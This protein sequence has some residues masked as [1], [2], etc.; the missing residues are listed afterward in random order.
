[1]GF[2]REPPS[3]Q[4]C[5]WEER[6]GAPSPRPG[7]SGGRPLLQ[8]ALWVPPP[9]SALHLLLL[10]PTA[11][12]RKRRVSRPAR[13]LADL[14]ELPSGARGVLPICQ[15]S[16]QVTLAP[17]EMP[18]GCPLASCLA[19]LGRQEGC[20]V[21]VVSTWVRTHGCPAGGGGQG[22]TPL[23]RTSPSVSRHVCAAAHLQ[24]ARLR[25]GNPVPPELTPAS[26]GG[27]ARTSRLWTRNEHTCL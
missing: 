22:Q 27:T 9:R 15:T 23:L 26:G 4:S 16:F 10:V 5:T 17:P 11:P 24:G 13:P 18:P 2:Y 21:R 25:P 8:E 1:M 19:R 20:L 7:R 3:E 12:P 14:K 6:S